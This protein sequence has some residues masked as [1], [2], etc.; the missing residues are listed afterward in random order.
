ML[1]LAEPENDQMLV[2]GLPLSRFGYQNYHNQVAGV[3]Q[4]DVLFAGSLADNIALFDDAPEMDLIISSSEAASIHEDIMA[5][6]MQ[7]ETLVG[8]MGSTLSSGQHQHI[9]LARALYRKPKILIMDEGT[10]N[11]DIFNEE[12]INKSVDTL[13]ITRII[14]AHRQSTVK[15]ADKFYVIA[16]GQIF[17]GQETDFLSY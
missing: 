3:L 4:D 11:L 10:A 7:Y 9:I 12:K 2:D 17:N 6:P 5:M 13:S 14:V 15:Q 16:D 8:D 1:G